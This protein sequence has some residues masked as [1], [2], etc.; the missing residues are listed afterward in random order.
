MHGWEFLVGIV[1]SSVLGLLVEGN[2]LQV[3][4]LAVVNASSAPSR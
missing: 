2:V 1:P 4:F 3:V